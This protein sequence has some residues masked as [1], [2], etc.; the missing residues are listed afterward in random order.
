MLNEFKNKN[1]N[2]CNIVASAKLKTVND[3]DLD[4]VSSGDSSSNECLSGSFVLV[5]KKKTCL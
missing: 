3:S 4:K 1:I 2:I 5:N